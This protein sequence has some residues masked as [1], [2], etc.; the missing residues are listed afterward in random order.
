MDVSDENADSFTVLA[1]ILLQVFNLWSSPFLCR[2]QCNDF[3]DDWSPVPAH[4][5]DDVESIAAALHGS[6]SFGTLAGD[7]AVPSCLSGE[8]VV[9]QPVIPAAAHVG[10]FARNLFTKCDVTGVTLPWETGFFR[11][12]FSDEPFAEQLVPRCP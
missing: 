12:L 9:P 2:H 1:M 6:A 11:E 5:G 4:A 10:N 3:P 7:S 8:P